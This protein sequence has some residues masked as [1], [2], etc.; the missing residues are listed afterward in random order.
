[1]VYWGSG[2]QFE[3]S[4]ISRSKEDASHVTHGGAV[5]KDPPSLSDSFP[6]VSHDAPNQ[7]VSKP[8]SGCLQLAGIF[9]T[10]S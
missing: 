2:L 7:N 10:A 8:V 4:F 6:S 3:A 9:I 1:M 5:A